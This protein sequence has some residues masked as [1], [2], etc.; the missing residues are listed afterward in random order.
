MLTLAARRLVWAIVILLTLAAVV[1]FLQQISPLD[2]VRAELGAQASAK[3][4]SDRRHDL[5]LDR[6]LL[7]QLWHYLGG[8]LHGD[9][10]SSYRT[11]RPVTTDLLTYLPATVELTITGLFFAIVLASI[12]AFG[13]V[14][15]WPGT[16]I[17]RAALLVG[18]SAPAFLLGI[19]GIVVFYQQLGWLPANGRTSDPFGPTGPTGLLTLDGLLHGDLL[20]TW[21]AIQHLILPGLAIAL[22]PAVAIGRVLRSSLLA[23]QNGD[24]ARTARAKG[25]TEWAILYRHL[26]RNTLGAAMSM[27]GL[28]LGLMFAGVLVVEQVFGWPGVGQYVAQSIPTADFPAIAGVTIV[29][30]ALY[31]AI[32]T[33]VDLLQAVADP[34]IRI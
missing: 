6:P 11:H 27:T 31:V 8:L 19:G 20:V 4:V 25:L 13:S 16:G 32:N 15:H 22:V 1:Y 10:G 21:D 5:G 33:V 29:L 17:F 18:A 34:R 12:F 7:V 28:Q 26:L 3:A 2:P 23:D 9:L 24:Y 30:G 14:L